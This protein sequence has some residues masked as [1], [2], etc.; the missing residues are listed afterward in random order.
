MRVLTGRGVHTKPRRSLVGRPRVARRR[1]YSA[2]R[3]VWD[4]LVARY[5]RR[6]RRYWVPI[7]PLRLALDPATLTPADLAFVGVRRAKALALLELPRRLVLLGGAIEVRRCDLT[8]LLRKARLLPATPDLPALAG[9]SVEA[10]LVCVAISAPLRAAA[11]AL[12]VTVV[13]YWPTWARGVEPPRDAPRTARRHD[14][15]V[16]LP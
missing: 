2:D 15:D 14:L 13:P 12:G 11:E 9:R 7:G 6:P 5:P 1:T 3:L 4:Y 8:E 10:R 16:T